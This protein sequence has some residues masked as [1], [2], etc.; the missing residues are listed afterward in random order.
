MNSM[1]QQLR[2][3]SHQTVKGGTSANLLLVMPEL[4]S[5]IQEVDLANISLRAS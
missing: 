3:R 1:E 5:F 2:L 4:V